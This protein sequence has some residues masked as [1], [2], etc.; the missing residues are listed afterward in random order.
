MMKLNC[1]KCDNKKKFFISVKEY[2]T[3]QVNEYGAFEKDMGFD[4]ADKCDEF[5]CL[6][7][8]ESAHWEPDESEKEKFKK[9]EIR[10]PICKEENTITSIPVTLMHDLMDVNPHTKHG[11]E[12]R[13]GVITNGDYEV[14]CT[15]CEYKGQLKEFICE[16]IEA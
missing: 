10:C 14:A 12:Q 9:T 7:C 16:K 1:T 5:W 11:P 6:E 3:W 4:D 13:M 8:G 15:N 2:H